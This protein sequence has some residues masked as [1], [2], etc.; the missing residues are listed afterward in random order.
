MHLCLSDANKGTYNC[1]Q[2]Q[3]IAA[4]G[5]WNSHVDKL[6]PCI[7]LNPNKTQFIWLGSGRPLASVD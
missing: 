4:T 7:L 6:N 2:T 3:T 1:A 5:D